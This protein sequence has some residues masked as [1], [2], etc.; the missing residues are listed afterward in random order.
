MANLNK[1]FRY[2]AI[3]IAKRR[4]IIKLNFSSWGLFWNLLI[5]IFEGGKVSEQNIKN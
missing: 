2:P 1:V 4:V 5:F 3:M